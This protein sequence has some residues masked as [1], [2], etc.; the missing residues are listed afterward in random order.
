MTLPGSLPPRRNSRWEDPF[1]SLEMVNALLSSVGVPSITA[2]ATAPYRSLFTTLQRQLVGR[3]ITARVG[4]HDVTLTVTEFDSPLDPRGL[5][6]GQ[7]GEV[8]LAARDI[9][10]DRHRLDHV[11]ALLEN[12][13]VRPG[14]PAVLVAAPVTLSAEL[15]AEAVY[16]VLHQ[17]VPRVRGELGPDGTARLRWARRPH[18][19]AL[20]VGVSVAGSTLWFKPQA[21]LIRRRRWA[22]PGWIPSYPVRL[23]ALPRGLT[24]TGAGIDVETLRWSGLLPQ[25]RIELPQV[26]DLLRY[27]SGRAGTLNLPWLRGS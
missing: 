18:W 11:T 16:P 2:G 12:V 5:A 4:D 10:W 20:E 22:L 13:H 8:R 9:T 3:E 27:V 15:S 26:D 23:P 24:V 17:A 6:M 14:A 21:L 1:R 25:W 7:F 19:G